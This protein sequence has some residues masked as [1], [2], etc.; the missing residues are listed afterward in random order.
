MES[1][2]FACI[3]DHVELAFYSSIDLSI[4]WCL[5]FPISL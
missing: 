4:G 1:K 2:M 5:G 3:I